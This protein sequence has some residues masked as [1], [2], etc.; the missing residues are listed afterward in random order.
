MRMRKKPKSWTVQ[1]AKAKF[2]ELV[3]TSLKEGPQMVTRRGIETVVIVP[4]DQWTGAIA[5][6]YKNIKDWLLAPGARADLDL[7]DRK[8]MK[9]R[10]APGV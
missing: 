8:T 3:E 4:V 2:S 5:P 1:E 7:P 9:W 10:K 6:R